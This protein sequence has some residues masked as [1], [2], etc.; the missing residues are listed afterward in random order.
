[1]GELEEATGPARL[2]HTKAN[3]KGV[4]TQM[5]REGEN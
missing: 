1:M 2:A 5:R 4:L 3:D